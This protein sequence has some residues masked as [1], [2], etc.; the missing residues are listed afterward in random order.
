MIAIN[1]VCLKWGT[2]YGP[3]YVNRLRAAIV[4]NTRIP[5]K[6]HCFTDNATGLHNDVIVHPLKYKNLDSWWNKLYLFSD[7]IAIPQ[8]ERIFYV[9]LDTLITGNIDRLLKHQTSKLV[10]LKDFYHGIAKSAGIVGSGLMSWHHGAFTNVWTSFIANPVTAVEMMHPHGDQMWIQHQVPEN[11]RAY[12]QDLFPNAVVSFKMHCGSGLPTGACVVC[13]HGKPSIPESALEPTKDWKFD[14]PAQPWVLEYWKDQYRCSVRHVRI[15]A[16]QIF[17]MIGRSGGGYNTVWGD[18]SPEGRQRRDEIVVKYEEE[19]NRI[20]G[21]YDKLESSILTEGMRNPLVVTCG[22]PVRRS[23]EQLPPELRNKSPKDLL[24]LEGTTGGSRLWVAQKHGLE[25][26]CIVNDWT[27]R[28]S[29]YPEIKTVSDAKQLYKDQPA[30]ATLDPTAGFTEV[31]DRNKVAYHLGTEWSED[32]L[33]E[34]RAVMWVSLMNSHGYVVDRLP[35]FVNDLLRKNGVIQPIPS[36]VKKINVVDSGFDDTV[37]LVTGGFDPLHSGHIE[38][39]KQA[40]ELGDR[41]VVGINS[42]DWLTRK[43]GRPFMPFSERKAIIEQ[44]RMV[45]EVI[46]FDDADNSAC[47][48]IRQVKKKYKRSHIVFANGGD[49]TK[50]NIPEM[51]F[52][53]V[54]FVFGIGGSD[55]KNSS[56]WILKDWS[57]AKVVRPWGYYRV[58]YEAPGIKVK[59]LTVDP[60]KN[61][62]MQR[63]QYR[64]EYWL[65][66]SGQAHVNLISRNSIP[67]PARHIRK[68][69]IL[70]IAAKEWHQLINPYDEPCHI[71]EIQYG[72]QCEE[73]DIERK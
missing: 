69:D 57:A 17:G 54:G 2:K 22:Y 68:H 3:E 59:E 46:A 33:L 53:D 72:S 12:W 9:D 37:V 70:N 19:M 4:K 58:L 11:R 26:D 34:S 39:F 61:L 29:N 24:L 41:L 23:I 1:I 52:E 49:R 30:R 18:W 8:G 42:D 5:I 36:T 16:R 28:Y 27:G 13:Y 15:P 47:D 38:Y 48:A 40:R 65:V 21:H 62:S 73:S 60:G 10:A 56:S 45:D 35:E 20:C 50:D 71:I 43:K 51:I 67:L 44:L 7:E 25:V 64:S 14:F 32:R 63:H 66:A 31:F 6:F 55:K